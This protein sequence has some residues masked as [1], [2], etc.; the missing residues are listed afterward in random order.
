MSSLT[1]LAALPTAISAAFFTAIHG[2]FAAATSARP[3]TRLPAACPRVSVLKPVAGR[4]D[5]LLGNLESF[6]ELDYPDYE[7]VLGVASPDDPAVPVIKAFLAAHPGLAARLVL[8]TPPR[9]AITNPKV[10]Q[11]IDLERETSGSVLVI[12]D[13]NVRVERAYLRTLVAALHRPGVGLVS[14]V[15]AGARP[16]TLAAAIDAA[17]LG[18]YIAPSVVTAHRLGLWPITVGKSMAMRRCDLAAVGGFQ[19]VAAVLAEDDVLGRRFH[20]AGLGVDL[21]L[22]PIESHDPAA[23]WTGVLGRHA[24]WAKLRRSL[25]PAG[26]AFEVLLSPLL[27]AAVVALV[28]PSTTALAALAFA[29]V[30]S[31]AGALLSL[32]RLGA[33]G[34]PTLAAIEPL[35][36]AAMLGC[37]VV[38]WLDRGVSWRG[39]A[40]DLAPGSRLVPSEG[41]GLAVR[42]ATRA[43]SLLAGGAATLADLAVLAFAMGV[44]G[45]SPRAANLP[46][47]CAGAA[48]QFLGN[49]HFVFRA[50]SGRIDRQLVLFLAA[51]AIGLVVNAS[52]YHGVASF[53]PLTRAGAIVARILTSNIVFVLWS[54]PVWTRIF[55]PK[56]AEQAAPEARELAW[57]R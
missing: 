27:V 19:T 15:I 21:C 46:A 36:V 29:L 12:S 51:E 26:F 17:Q 45:A 18:A 20:A 39:H 8:T 32:R 56:A 3:S 38:A 43:R 33:R 10:A 24:R 11:L 9:G 25:T 4:D 55:R 41:P 6:A 44:L 47:L 5:G 14:N 48:V 31:W 2:T 30:L 50:G 40:F 22:A 49:R 1:L 35:R 13:A 28:A 16:G 52:L 37:W 34:A 7:L 53:F 42:L 23:S 57:P 54:Y